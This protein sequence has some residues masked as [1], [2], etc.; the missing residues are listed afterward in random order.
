VKTQPAFK[1]LVSV[2][3]LTVAG[4]F[5]F[6][7]FH[8][9]AEPDEKAYFYDLS[10]QKLFVASRRAVPPIRGINN[11]EQ[12]GVR[13]I[14]ISTSGTPTDKR[15]VKI[16]YLEKY[17][18]ELKQQIEAMQNTNAPAPAGPRIDRVEAQ[19]FTFVRRVN[20]AQWQPVNSPE[21]E[22]IMGEWLVPGANGQMPVVCVP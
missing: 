11:D 6:R 21:A 7:F 18:P 19:S 8:G 16:A 4:F 9:Q 22:K 20:E 15:T 5:L 2:I 10:E 1:L 17:S 13:A 3:A 14:V 12:D